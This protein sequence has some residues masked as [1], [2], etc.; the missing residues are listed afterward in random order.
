[1]E[2]VKGWYEDKKIQRTLTALKK[3]GFHT[4]FALTRRDACEEALNL[5]PPNAQ[6]GVGGSTTIREIN[7]IERLNERGNIV[8]QH[9][10][11]SPG[12]GTI[13]TMRKA[14][15]SDVFLSSSNAVTE[16]GKLINTDGTGNRVAAMIFGPTKVIV[17]AGIN[18]IVKDVA[19]GIRRIKNVAGPMNVRRLNM[20]K[21][22]KYKTPC[23]VTGLCTD[24]DSQD[25]ICRVTTILERTPDWGVDIAVIL[26][27]EELG[28]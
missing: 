6:V 19:E 12:E 7:L 13:T 15:A 18:K 5:I 25:R 21:K 24:C 22:T 11:P 28:F 20:S 9:W 2:E 4:V 27:G 16:D 3:N 14:M 10:L 1:M 8:V 17:I 26:V 23:A